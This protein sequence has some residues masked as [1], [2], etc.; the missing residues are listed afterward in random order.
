M[1]ARDDRYYDPMSPGRSALASLTVTP[2]PEPAT[3]A[4]TGAGVL[5]L[6]AWTRRR[7][8]A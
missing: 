6:G 5:A 4:L 1:T 8:Q 2:V 7:R 3:I